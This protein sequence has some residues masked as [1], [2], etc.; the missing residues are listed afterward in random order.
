MKLIHYI[1]LILKKLFLK[2]PKNLLNCTQKGIFQLAK[3]FFTES[4]KKFF[5]MF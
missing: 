3:K 2:K 1:T 4:A 5:H